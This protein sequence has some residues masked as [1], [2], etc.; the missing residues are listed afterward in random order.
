[1]DSKHLI[2]HD[3]RLYNLEKGVV[4]AFTK[5]GKK[6]K[7]KKKVETISLHECPLNEWVLKVYEIVY[8]AL[9]I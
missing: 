3:A 1:M 9:R 7:E 5:K 8:N 4:L 2:K 6:E